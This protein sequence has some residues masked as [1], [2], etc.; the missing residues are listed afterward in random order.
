[1]R[2]ADVGVTGTRC[3]NGPQH[4]RPHV[5]WSAAWGLSNGMDSANKSL[6]LEMES[7]ALPATFT[8]GQLHQVPQ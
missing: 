3:R 4:P 7:H 6:Q 1:M 8:K 5:Q 2:T